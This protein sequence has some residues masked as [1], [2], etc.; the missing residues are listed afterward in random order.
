MTKPGFP[1]WKSPAAGYMLKTLMRYLVLNGLFREGADAYAVPGI[2]SKHVAYA[3]T[4]G[5]D[6]AGFDAVLLDK[7]GL[8]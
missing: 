5:S 6:A 3:L 7:R 4:F 8:D 1:F 2:F